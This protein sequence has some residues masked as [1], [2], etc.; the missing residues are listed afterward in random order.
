MLHICRLLN[1]IFCITHFAISIQIYSVKV[2]KFF[3]N[4][5]TMSHFSIKQLRAFIALRHKDDD[6]F[7][8]VFLYYFLKK[9]AAFLGCYF[10]PPSFLPWSI[11]EI[12]ILIFHFAILHYF[13]IS[14]KNQNSS[15]MYKYQAKLVNLQVPLTYF[16]FKPLEIVP[17]L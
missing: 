15:N 2:N 6:V 5:T 8:H 10:F 4:I 16:K 14:C 3:T 9:L 12:R 11:S 7:L 1:F 17:I 13:P